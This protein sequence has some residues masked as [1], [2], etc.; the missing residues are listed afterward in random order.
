MTSSHQLQ[1]FEPEG[2]ALVKL[3]AMHTKNAEFERKRA[4]NLTLAGFM[5][6]A[7]HC[8]KSALMF[9]ENAMVCECAYQFERLGGVS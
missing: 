1:M 9:D 3:V 4:E 8:A 2:D 7:F 5:S 6:S